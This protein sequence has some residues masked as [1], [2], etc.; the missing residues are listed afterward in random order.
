MKRWLHK[1]LLSQLVGYF[2]LL[3]LVTVST[4]AIGSFFLAR[5]ALETEVIN[6]LTV[7]AELKR[8]QLTQWVQNQLSDVLLVS[9]DARMQATVKRLLTVESDDPAYE[10]AQQDL[11]LQ[12]ANLLKL[13]PNLRSIRI[14]RN[15]GFV[16][17][18][19]DVPDLEGAYRPL[20][21]PATYFTSDRINVIVP[22]FYIS[23]DT[24]KAAITV[25]TPILDDQKEKMA[26]LIADFNLDEVDHL[27][28]ENTGL[29][30]T[31]ETYL[32]GQVKGKNLFI[33]KQEISD[34]DAKT[35][36]V[37]SETA[38]ITSK[39]IERA[40]SQQNGF[41]LYKNY[42]GIPV[43]G[44]Y[45]WLPEENLALIAEI[46]QSIAFLPARSLARNIEII[47]LLLSGV[48]LIAVYVLSRRITRPILAISEAARCLAQGDL[49]QTAPVMTED[50]VGML[51]RTFNQMASQLKASFE[52]LE[53][54]VAQ[55]T[56]ELA[57]AKE[58]ADAA[59]QAKSEFLANMSHE[60]RT[61]LNGILGYAQILGRTKTLAPKEKTGVNVIHQCGS[62]LLTLINDILDLSKIE[63]RKLELL[64][65]TIHL[66]YLLQS[67]V[68][69]CE[70]RAIQKSIEF[71]YQPSS[72]LPEGI[73]IDSKRLR[74]VLINLLNNAIKFTDHG[75]VTLQV[76]TLMLNE[77]HA[78]LLFQIIDTGV[79]IAEE[80]F[81]Q[82][83][84]AFEQVGE[85]KKQAEGTGL[86]LAISQR[87]VQLMGS[88]IQVKSQ[89]GQGSEFFFTLDVPVVKD[90]SKAQEVSESDRIVGYEVVNVNASKEAR[91]NIL[92]IDDRWENRAVL[93]N[94]LESL[95]F[96]VIEA[97]NGQ[98]GLD[99]LKAKHPE[100]VITDL[101]M[102]IMDG[103]EF[104]QHVRNS[105]AL[106]NAKVIVSSASV[107]QLDQQMALDA[108]GDDFLAKPVDVR[109]LIHLL[110]THLDI[111]W[112]Q[113]ANDDNSMSSTL[114]TEL[115]VPPR[116]VLESL[117]EPAQ[118]GDLKTLCEHLDKLVS[119]EKNYMLFAEPMRKLAKQFK[120]EEIEELL[121]QYIAKEITHAR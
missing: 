119:A 23:P 13:K 49:S 32:I 107:T 55:R 100:L 3:S 104:L 61:P 66:S 99:Q 51:A 50:E 88:S 10:T 42:Q 58:Q 36:I 105:E 52:T 5:R 95:D 21:N 81:A 112:I 92:V 84:E 28:R 86:G 113:E 96:R 17:F 70:M 76:D 77:H 7:A 117:L 38:S 41:D 65:E 82:L 74:Q 24:Q 121:E 9:Q 101:A 18:A 71:V 39:G 37:D 12:V 31:A 67:V 57:S 30:D 33:S 102:P 106:K 59:N 89:L 54:R 35:T 72:H 97:C 56:A 63:A 6:R 16:V 19:S 120:V 69:M 91:Y 118:I 34:N 109:E 98:D 83:F 79:G 111:E 90:W 29:G 11:T 68:E 93:V 87:I 22:N 103:F 85:R 114:T 75:T 25:A 73:E 44:V 48:L 110:A 60:L 78:K 15:S 20:G 43:V 116:E 27:I 2:S 80:D 108:G 14:T 46:E 40:I 26:I 115:I 4:V 47:G 64:P 62:H 94:L 45:R 8:Y 1:S 53:Y